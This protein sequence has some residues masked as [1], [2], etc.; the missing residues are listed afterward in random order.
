MAKMV[1]DERFGELTFAQRAAYRKYNVSQ[2]DHDMLT[3]IVR[4]DDHAG[5]TDIVKRYS[6]SG[7][8]DVFAACRDLRIAREQ[9][10]WDLQ[11]R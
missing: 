7:N 2:S 3:D 10:V 5:L 8:F 4:E 9:Q 6:P 11:R 1:F